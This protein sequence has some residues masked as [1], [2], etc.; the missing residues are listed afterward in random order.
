[1]SSGSRGPPVKEI[2]DKIVPDLPSHIDVYLPFGFHDGVQNVRMNNTHMPVL[3]AVYHPLYSTIALP[4]AMGCQRS[5]VGYVNTPVVGWDKYVKQWLTCN[6]SA[7][8]IKKAV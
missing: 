8:F 5:Q 4:F 1:M 2:L 6:T 7:A 3:G